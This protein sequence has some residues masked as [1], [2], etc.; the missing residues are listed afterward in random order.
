MKRAGFIPLAADGWKRD[1]SEIR[2]AWRYMAEEGLLEGMGARGVNSPDMDERH[3]IWFVLW[4]M[5]FGS[6]RQAIEQ[7]KEL[8]VLPLTEIRLLADGNFRLPEMSVGRM[9]GRDEGEAS[10]LRAGSDHFGSAL[11]SVLRTDRFASRTA[12]EALK[13]LLAEMAGRWRAHLDYIQHVRR[14][15][16]AEFVICLS[17]EE[18]NPNH[19]HEIDRFMSW[20]LRF[21]G[22]TAH[23]GET[24]DSRT[25]RESTIEKVALPVMEQAPVAADFTLGSA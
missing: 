20:R 7:A 14:P 3:L 12:G 18:N 5:S 15:A 22:Y 1:Q 10:V 13:L 25:I 8:A 6:A 4:A 16:D 19:P 21:S 9:S 17:A 24:V 11:P 2:T 23:V